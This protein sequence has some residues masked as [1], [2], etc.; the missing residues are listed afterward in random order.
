MSPLIKMAL[1]ILIVVCLII[2]G[3]VILA[4]FPTRIKSLPVSNPAQSY[5]DAL[6][7]IQDIQSRERDNPHINPACYTRLLTHDQETERA[8]VLLHGFT[9]CPEQFAQLG[10]AFYQKGY[11]VYIPRMPGHGYYQRSGEALKNR[12]PEEMLTFA[13]ESADIGR[14]LGAGLTVSGL[15]G[16]GS[17]AVWLAQERGDIDLAAP[18]SPFLGI[19]FIPSAL[20]RPLANLANRLPD[21]F[22]W[23]D[24][25]HKAN[26]P[27]TA[28]YAY[29]RY[30]VHALDNFLI[31]GFSTKHSA[32]RTAPAAGQI[33]MV[34]NA[35]DRSVNN[36]INQRMVSIWQGQSGAKVHHYQFPKDLDL[37][38]DLITPTR[39]G[40][41]IDLVYPKLVELLGAAKKSTGAVQ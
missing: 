1:Y 10:E 21:F 8:I 13:S 40:S 27:L 15:S 35:S 25:V 30:P 16:G 3:L 26:N 2:I 4:L 9:S 18:I 11:N 17:L 34:T 39:K 7:R 23:W 31:I 33:I 19:G 14:G 20:N 37:P 36:D 38:H 29:T 24:P 6:R 12:T 22:Q 32:K 5:D 28:S 41:R